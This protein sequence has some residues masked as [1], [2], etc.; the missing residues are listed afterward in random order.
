MSIVVALFVGMVISASEIV[1]DRNILK[2][3]AFLNLSYVSYI[4]SKVVYLFALSFIQV[5]TYVLV[6]NY[7][8]KIENLNLS[9]I[10]ILWTVAC[11]ANLTGLL[12]STILKSVTAIYIVIPFILIPQ[13]LLAGV[14]VNFDKLH[15][16]AASQKYVPFIADVITSRWAFEALAI[17]QYKNNV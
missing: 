9:Y 16:I 15:H 2:R 11:Y 12:I 8:L 13:I 1:K 7:L 17:N 3:E 4:N 10:I 5:F 6:A 14:V